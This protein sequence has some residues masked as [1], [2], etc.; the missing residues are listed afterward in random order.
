MRK[1]KSDNNIIFLIIFIIIIL[2]FI[3]GRQTKEEI[4]TIEDEIVEESV[5]SGFLEIET[6]PSNA[7][8]FMDNIY[9]GKSPITL[10]NVPI[11]PHNIVIKKKGYEDFISEVNIDAGRKTFLEADLVL[12]P[13]FEEKPEIIEIVEEEEE[14]LIGTLKASGTVNIGKKFLLYYDFSE[15]EFINNKQLDLDVFSKRYNTHIVFTRFNPANIKTID[16]SIENV[17]KEDCIDIKGQFEFLYSGQSLCVITKENEI[18]AIG[19]EWE[20]TENAELKWKLF[21]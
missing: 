3:F 19:G 13:T 20:N 9:N 1:I 11:G 8:I 17:K 18:V 14:I 7:E 21:S 12:I 16:K 4:E 15:G 10:Y 5:G 6:L 2:I